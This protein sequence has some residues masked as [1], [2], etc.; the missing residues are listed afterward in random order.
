MGPTI[1]FNAETCYFE[2]IELTSLTPEHKPKR[3]KFERR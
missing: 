1:S 2:K 3:A